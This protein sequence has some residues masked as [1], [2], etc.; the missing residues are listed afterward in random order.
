LK[1]QP[2]WVSVDKVKDQATLTPSSA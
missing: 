1:V 2:T